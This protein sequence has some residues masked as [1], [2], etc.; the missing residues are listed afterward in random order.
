MI[1][2]ICFYIAAFLF[3]LVAATH[4]K[5]QWVGT[6]DGTFGNI[7]SHIINTKCIGVLLLDRMSRVI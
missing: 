7:A 6:A 1:N 5:E 3:S 4:N 2:V